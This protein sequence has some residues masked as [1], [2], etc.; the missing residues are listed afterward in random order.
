MVEKE[1]TVE[2][3]MMQAYDHGR[4]DSIELTESGKREMDSL[5]EYKKEFMY[6]TNKLDGLK[7]AICDDRYKEEYEEIVRWMKT[8]TDRA[9]GY[10][11][12]KLHINLPV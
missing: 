4:S 11:F 12:N 2:D 1:L 6:I 10:Y 3:V 8:V 9:Y 5:S 7:S